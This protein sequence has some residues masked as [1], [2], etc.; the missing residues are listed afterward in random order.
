MDTVRFV[1]SDF[2][3]PHLEEAASE[4]ASFLYEYRSPVIVRTFIEFM[5]VNIRITLKNYKPFTDKFFSKVI[6]NRRK[7]PPDLL[8]LEKLCNRLFE[9]CESDDEII[10]MRGLIPEKLFGM[11]FEKRH[12]GKNCNIGYGAKVLING[13]VI[14]YQPKKPFKTE[15]DSDQPRKTIDAGFWDGDFGEFVEIKLSP[16][17]FQTKEIKYLKLLESELQKDDLPHTIFL[18]ALENKDLIKHRLKRL[19]LY[20][21]NFVL[22]GK[23]ELFDLE[24]AS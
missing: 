23:E 6:K 19:N 18:V 9:A 15:D 20:Y 3:Y 7:A 12:Y 13:K 16:L 24:K 10:K 14:E 17:A 5:R 11:I 1:K 8:Q 21:D 2:S 22:V 4:I